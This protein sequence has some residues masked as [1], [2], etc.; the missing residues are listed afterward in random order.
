MKQGR[1]RRMLSVLWVVLGLCTLTAIV[2]F[3][4]LSKQVRKLCKTIFN[5]PDWDQYWEDLFAAKVIYDGN[6]DRQLVP[7]NSKNIG[8][9][10]TLASCPA[11]SYTAGDPND[12]GKQRSMC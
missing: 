3:D 4:I 8:Y 2:D 5:Y 1:L 9:F 6:K 11:D 12:P 7:S 10:L